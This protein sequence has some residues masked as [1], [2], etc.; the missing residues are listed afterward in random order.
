MDQVRNTRR[1]RVARSFLVFEE[2]NQD[3]LIFLWTLVSESYITHIRILEDAAHPSNPPPLQSPSENKKPRV[4]VIA[5][6][7]SGRVRMHKAREN[8]NGSF[9]IGKTWVLDDLTMIQSFTNAIPLTSEEQQNKERAG[10]TGFVVT[11]QKPYYWQAATAKEKDFF[12]YSLIKIYKKYT[13][14][15]LPE[16]YGFDP[17][18]LEQLAGASGPQSGAQPKTPKTPQT[19]SSKGENGVFVQGPSSAQGRPPVPQQAERSRGPGGDTRS[20][21]SPERS[22]RERAPQIRSPQERPIQPRSSQ[23]RILRTTDSNDRMPYIPGQYPSSEF[24]RNLN[25]Q[26][27]RPPIKNKRSDSPGYNEIPG[28]TSVQQE[29]NFRKQPGA[30]SGDSFRTRQERTLGKATPN[31]Q[32]SEERVRQ[33]SDYATSTLEK[34]SVGQQ[35]DGPDYDKLPSTLRAGSSEHWHPSQSHRRDGRPSSSSSKPSSSQKTS[36]TALNYEGPAMAVALEPQGDNIKDNSNSEIQTEQGDRSGDSHQ[37]SARERDEVSVSTDPQVENQQHLGSSTAMNNI[38]PPSLKQTGTADVHAMTSPPPAMN[39][40]TNSPPEVEEH[41]P[42]LG[43]MI[44]KKS[45]KEIA[46]TFRKAATAYNAFKPRPGGAA[47]KFRNENQKSFSEHDGISSVFPAPS[48]LK[49]TVQSSSESPMPSQPPN[50][51]P[52]DTEPRE[53]PTINI[54]TSSAKTIETVDSEASRQETLPSQKAL[55]APKDEADERSKK[56]RSDHSSKYARMLGINQSLLEG[57][58]YEIES[59]LNDFGWGEETRERTTYEELQSGLRKE[60]NRVEAGSWL[61]ALENNDERVTAV[62]SM[63]DRVMA[64]CEEL[65][66]L[67]T[68]YNVELGVRWPSGYVFG[69]LLTYTRL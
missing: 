68:L 45:N 38:S 6:R 31:G 46:S 1:E 60:I 54:D 21:P 59:M 25:P 65:D 35:L 24:V 37:L 23:E 51:G 48:L 32:P 52:F 67:L 66:S 7:K 20:R 4:I 17:Q 55:D 8:A 69:Y 36:E 3:K 28:S 5:V 12:I 18:E 42:G 62:G 2:V 9:S 39:V 44:K 53:L 26:T 47:E 27:S 33:T 14:G 50:V 16:L 40:S 49:S 29:S 13:G 30:Q 61:G 41:R 63:M 57:R 15:N 10:A 34:S 56:R 58:T 22:S 64:E 11:I 19:Q 43:P